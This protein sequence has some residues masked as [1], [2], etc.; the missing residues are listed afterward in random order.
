MTPSILTKASPPA[1]TV[2]AAVSTVQAV[3]AQLLFLDEFKLPL[4]VYCLKLSTF[5]NATIF[6]TVLTY[7]LSI[8]RGGVVTA[9][10][11]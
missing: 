9:P 4:Y 2:P 3:E 7:T 10:C 5:I 1:L 11:G 6:A 8:A